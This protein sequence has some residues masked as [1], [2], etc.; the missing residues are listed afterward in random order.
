MLEKKLHE[1]LMRYKAI[2][3]YGEKMIMEQEATPEEPVSPELPVDSTLPPEGDVPTEEPALDTVEPETD[4]TE[5]I[6]MELIFL[7][8]RD[9]IW[10]ILRRLRKNFC[11]PS[12]TGNFDFV[13]RQVPKGC[14]FENV[15]NATSGYFS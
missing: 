9:S 3:R 5:E 14:E 4:S 6:D 7:G 10:K 12:N 15:K 8:S 13:G 11:S 2:N 1:E